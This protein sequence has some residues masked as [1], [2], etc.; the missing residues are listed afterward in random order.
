M[1]C[2]VGAYCIR[3]ICEN[4]FPKFGTAPRCAKQPNDAIC[5][6]NPRGCPKCEPKLNSAVKSRYA[7][8][9]NTYSP[10]HNQDNRK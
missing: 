3:P 9:F 2:F 10:T 4:D 5:R 7:K 1:I 6:G 8:L